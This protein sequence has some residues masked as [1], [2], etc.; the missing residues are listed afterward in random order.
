MAESGCLRDAHFM[1]LEVSGKPF[2]ARANHVTQAALDS[3]VTSHGTTGAITLASGQYGAAANNSD[4][5]VQYPNRFYLNNN[6][7][8]RDSNIFLTLDHSGSN[9]TDQ[10]TSRPNLAFSVTLNNTQSLRAGI[11]V[12]SVG[13]GKF[14]G[15]IGKL[16]YLVIN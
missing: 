14:N 16:K 12:T 15:S 4:I 7:I 1:N 5:S 13:N 2:F 9:F 6:Y 3:N 10:N 8:N 11:R